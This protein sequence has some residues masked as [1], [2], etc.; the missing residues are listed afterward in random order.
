MDFIVRDAKREDLPAILKINNS[1]SYPK[2]KDGFLIQKRSLE[3]FEKLFHISKHFL[4]SEIDGK[5]IGYLI[6]LD[7]SADYLENKLFSFYVNN[8]DAFVFVDQIALLPEFHGKGI[9]KALYKKLFESEKKR[10]LLDIFFKPKNQQS[11]SAHEA[12]GFKFIGDIIKLENGFEAG[13]YEY[14]RD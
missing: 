6:V 2:N 9:G 5:V 7:E 4:V 11:I 1:L 3:E 8:Y 14:N 10:L 13:V 12:I